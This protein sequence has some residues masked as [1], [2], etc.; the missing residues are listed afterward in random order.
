MRYDINFN[1][2]LD[3]LRDGKIDVST[4]WTRHKNRF[5]ERAN[6]FLGRY[7]YT[8]QEVEDLAQEGFLEVLIR[9]GIIKDSSNNSREWNPDKGKDWTLAQYIE[10]GIG[11]AIKSRLNHDLKRPDPKRGRLPITNIPSYQITMSATTDS[12]DIAEKWG[13]EPY[14]TSNQKSTENIP[15]WSSLSAEQS[16]EITDFINNFTKNIYERRVLHLVTKGLAKNYS[17]AQICLAIET[18]PEPYGGITESGVRRLLNQVIG[19]KEW[20]RY[21]GLPP[22]RN[23]SLSDQK[24]LMSEQ[25]TSIVAIETIDTSLANIKSIDLSKIIISCYVND[26]VRDGQDI[27]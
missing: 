11:H 8:G 12:E 14:V 20:R 7:L 24:E 6:Y 10:W 16:N 25:M 26:H 4:F 27:V 23:L 9:I 13:R 22:V 19:S 21:R 17:L 2:S 1:K 3:E 15:S 18:D 5:Y